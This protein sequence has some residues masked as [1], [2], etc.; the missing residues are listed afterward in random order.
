HLSE[1]EE[2]LA[3]PPENLVTLFYYLEA[4]LHPEG[5][6]LHGHALGP[7]INRLGMLYDRQCSYSEAEKCYRKGIELAPGN[8]AGHWN[9]GHMFI[10]QGQY[11]KTVSCIRKFKKIK[12]SSVSIGGEKNGREGFRALNHTRRKLWRGAPS[13]AT[14]KER[15]LVAH[16]SECIPS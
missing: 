9:L 3:Q 12:G 7:D 2:V 6:L 16:L 10:N 5:K 15:I 8:T 4:T 1:K 14:T 13:P 11:E